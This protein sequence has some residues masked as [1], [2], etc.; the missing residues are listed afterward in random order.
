MLLGL[1]LPAALT[2]QEPLR[3]PVTATPPAAV[4]GAVA[5]PVVVS[6]APLAATV[7]VPAAPAAPAFAIDPYYAATPYNP[8]VVGRTAPSGHLN[9]PNFT[10][11][12]DLP[13]QGTDPYVPVKPD[14]LRGKKGGCDGCGNGAGCGNGYGDG[15]GKLGWLGGLKAGSCAKGGSCTTC[16]NSGNFAFAS[17][18]SYFGESSRE[19]FERP[20]SVD[21]IKHQP[22]KYTPNAR[23][24]A[25]PAAVPAY[26]GP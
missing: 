21:G 9:R 5:P 16:C 10:L 12:C 6:P 11:P 4:P 23:R 1:S 7:P 15:N 2:A 24:A 14:W 25:P 22:V 20:P 26:V 13:N 19:F 3:P 18:R 8:T 17:S